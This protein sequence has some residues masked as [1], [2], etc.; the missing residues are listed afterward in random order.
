MDTLLGVSA[1][2]LTVLLPED[3]S[4]VWT[5]VRKRG[6]VDLTSAYLCQAE[7]QKLSA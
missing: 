1:S 4:F 6:A 7:D 5:A 3:G 2:A